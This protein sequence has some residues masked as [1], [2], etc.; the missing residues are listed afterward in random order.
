MAHVL[1]LNALPSVAQLG[2]KF[3][4]ADTFARLRR[5]LKDAERQGS[6]DH[7]HELLGEEHCQAIVDFLELETK[8]GIRRRMAAELLK[9]VVE[10]KGFDEAVAATEAAAAAASAA[11]SDPAPEAAEM[12][13]RLPTAHELMF[14]RG[15]GEAEAVFQKL[16]AWL[17]RRRA[18]GTLRS[19]AESLDASY[20]QE[21]FDFLCAFVLRQTP[22]QAEARDVLQQL[23]A[24]ASWAQGGA[25]DPTAVE[26]A[27]FGSRNIARQAIASIEAQG[28]GEQTPKLSPS[29]LAAGSRLF[30]LPPC[31]VASKTVSLPRVGLPQGFPSLS[32]F[33]ILKQ[34]GGQAEG[35]A[36]EGPPGLTLLESTPGQVDSK[37]WGAST[38]GFTPGLRSRVATLRGSTQSGPLMTHPIVPA[39]S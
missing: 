5:W 16:V 6:L 11:A 4:K 31:M 36:S 28:S 25:L 8:G 1:P 23:A 3:D 21:L 24:M 13:P 33:S 17:H 19:A 37:R 35:L 12:E 2:R 39:R 7:I 15:S 34:R 10:I 29:P 20:R 32:H 9:L 18:E 14:S 38:F 30:S 22:F 26:L 27:I